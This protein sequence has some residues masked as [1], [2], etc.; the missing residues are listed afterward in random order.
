MPEEEPSG[1]E[2]KQPKKRTA[3]KVAGLRPRPDL[4]S[5]PALSGAASVAARS[6]LGQG[7]GAQ[8][9]KAVQVP[10]SASQDA[11]AVPAPS[12]PPDWQGAAE[13]VA[14]DTAQTRAEDQALSEGAPPGSVTP[15]SVSATDVQP[16]EPARPHLGDLSSPGAASSGATHGTTPHAYQDLPDGEAAAQHLVAHDDEQQVPG[17]EATTAEMTEAE[18]RAGEHLHQGPGE[19]A[20]SPPARAPRWGPHIRHCSTHG[21]AAGWTSSSVGTP[22]RR[23]RSASRRTW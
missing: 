12:T 17:E 11:I 13:A 14:P 10:A 1:A 2:R 18:P 16:S 22:G 5:N 4:L 19:S 9:V 8:P 23:I 15:L 6:V 3:K 21:V 20:L 7:A